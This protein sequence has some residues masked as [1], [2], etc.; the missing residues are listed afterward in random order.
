M[1][2][3]TSPDG[4]TSEHALVNNGAQ[5]PGLPNQ[6]LQVL[7]MAQRTAEE[8][9]ATAHQQADKIRT[10]ALAA[11]EQIARDAQIHAH[12]V[13]READKVLF[14]ARAASEQNAR[15]ARAAAEDAQRHAD[16]IVAEAQARADGIAAEARANSEHLRVQAQQRYDDVVGSLGNKREALQ[17]QIEAL[18]QFDRE[19]RGR[20]TSFMQGQLRALWVDQP[21]VAGELED[22]EDARP[23]RHGAVSTDEPVPALRQEAMTEPQPEAQQAPEDAEEAEEE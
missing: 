23:G 8:H 14:D 5:M 17:E 13:R 10:D 19:Y 20:L 4:A 21:Q 7:T 3:G 22:P 12:N 2:L 15:D 16:K 9:V 11:A 6:A 18:E 1:M